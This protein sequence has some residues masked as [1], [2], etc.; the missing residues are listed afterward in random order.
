MYEH[1]LIIKWTGHLS[2]NYKK[3]T[4]K[5]QFDVELHAPAENYRS[6]IYL[7]ADAEERIFEKMEKMDNFDVTDY[8]IDVLPAEYADDEIIDADE[9]EILSYC[10]DTKFKTELVSIE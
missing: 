1:N 6:D 10:G 4:I 2:S 8:F 7:K 9:V 5:T 3:I